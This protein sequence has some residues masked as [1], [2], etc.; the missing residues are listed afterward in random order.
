MAK[1]RA[2]EVDGVLVVARD[3]REAIDAYIEY[4]QEFFKSGEPTVAN[5]RLLNNDKVITAGGQV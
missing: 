2:W 5:V 4:H 3:I 1:L